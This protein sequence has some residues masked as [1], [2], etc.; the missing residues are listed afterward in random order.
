MGKNKKRESMRRKKKK[1][2]LKRIRENNRKT[3][4]LGWDTKKTA[5]RVITRKEEPTKL[6]LWKRILNWLKG[7]S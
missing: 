7:K 3:I 5:R 1:R 6:S 2:R 4:G